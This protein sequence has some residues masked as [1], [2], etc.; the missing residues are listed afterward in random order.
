MILQWLY[1]DLVHEEEVTAKEEPKFYKKENW[2][3]EIKIYIINVSKQGWPLR[4]ALM[5]YFL[6]LGTAPFQLLPK[7]LPPL[8]NPEGSVCY[9]FS[10]CPR[11]PHALSQL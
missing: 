3:K 8:F 7:A 5:V 6:L 1:A 4:P 10:F 11:R 2:V 9:V